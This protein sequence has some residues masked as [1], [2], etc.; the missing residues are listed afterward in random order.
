M[1][2]IGVTFANRYFT[3][4]D[5]YQ[6]GKRPTQ[7]WLFS[8]EAAQRWW[9]TVV[10]HLLFGMNAHIHLDLGIAVAR[11]VPPES[12]EQVRDDFTRINNILADLIDQVQTELAATWTFYRVLDRLTHRH[13]EI[14][15]NFSLA[16]AR[17]QAWHVAQRL[18]A[19]SEVEQEREIL[20][21]DATAV[22]IAR[23]VLHPGLPAN[24]ILKVMRVG[25]RGTIAD[26]IDILR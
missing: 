25:E 2:H 17:D 19:L 6:N 7:A 24:F 9:P 3:A 26:I 5:Q 16:K 20:A 1:A 21:L 11:S 15:M 4:F 13:D 14:I 8:F 22:H 23:F 12:L 10:Q 18:V